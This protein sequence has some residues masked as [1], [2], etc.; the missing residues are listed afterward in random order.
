VPGFVSP[1]RRDPGDTGAI[2]AYNVRLAADSRLTV[3][4]LPVGDGV[5]VAIKNPEQ[6]LAARASG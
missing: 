6:R 2:A 4:W 5:A 3:S 1:P